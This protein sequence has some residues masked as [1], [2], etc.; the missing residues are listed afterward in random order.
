MA[1]DATHD[2]TNL[3]DK[4]LDVRGQRPVDC[5]QK[6]LEGSGAAPLDDGLP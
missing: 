6:A 2:Q 5:Y 3:R 1:K 4:D